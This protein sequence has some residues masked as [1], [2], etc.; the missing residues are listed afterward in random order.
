MRHA[1]RRQFTEDVRERRRPHLTADH[2]G[3]V[4]MVVALV[5]GF[6]AATYSI[7]SNGALDTFAAGR[8]PFILDQATTGLTSLRETGLQDL[9]VH[10]HGLAKLALIGKNVGHAE[11]L[12]WM[13]FGLIGVVLFSLLRFRFLWWPLHPVVCLMWGTWTA[14]MMWTLI[15]NRMAVAKH[16]IVRYGGGRTYQN[17]KPIFIGLIMG[18]LFAV[19]VQL[20]RWFLLL[21]VATRPYPNQYPGYSQD[22]PWRHRSSMFVHSITYP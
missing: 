19:T 6:G 2:D 22:K 10:T 3:V 8:Q 17:L 4:G 5:V 15:S 1:L 11:Q 20:V 13:C 16:L 12:S 9:A 14:D 21:H 7:Y 18:E